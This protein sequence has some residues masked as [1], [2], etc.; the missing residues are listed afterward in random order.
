METAAAAAA[1]AAEAA[2]L[3]LSGASWIPVIEP[4]LS[5]VLV[6]TGQLARIRS[7]ARVLPEDALYALEVRLA[8]ES[9]QVDLSLRIRR[10]DVADRVAQNLLPSLRRRFLRVWADNTR[11]EG[12][13]L[14]ELWLEFDLEDPALSGIPEPVLCVRLPNQFENDW[15]LDELM[16]QLYG[17]QLPSGLKRQILSCLGALPP[18]VDLLYIFDLSTRARRT[19]RLE[20]YA[21][22]LPRLVDYLDENVSAPAVEQISALSALCG[23]GD[24]FHLSLDFEESHVSDRIGLEMSYRRQ[25]HREPRWDGLFDRLVAAG[26]CSPSEHEAVFDWLGV[27]DPQSTE[28]WPVGAS[29]FCVRC[30]SHVKVLTWPDRPPEVKLYLLFQHF[31]KDG[32]RLD[33]LLSRPAK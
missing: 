8:S 7:V 21:D 13:Q 11:V 5:P 17:S 18:D 6:S 20:F 3:A 23:D 32:Q 1:E 24:R 26:L 28:D 16:P 33:S 14:P 19:I 4:H 25:P 12:S 9:E 2:D 10:P 31:T 22:E 30:L 27:D 15:F 29:G